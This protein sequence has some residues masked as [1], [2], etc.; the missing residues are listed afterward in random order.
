MS[1]PARPREGRE[2]IVLAPAGPGAFD[3]I[4][5]F[6]WALTRALGASQPSTLVVRGEPTLPAATFEAPGAPAIARMTSWSALS[7]APWPAR[8]RDAAG[9]FVQYYPQAY[10]APDLPPLMHWLAAHKQAGGAVVV[11]L[12]EYWPHASWSPPRELLRWRSRRALRDLVDVSTAMVVSQ[13]FSAREVID[14][15]LVPA[16]HLHVIPIGSAVPKTGPRTPAATRPVLAMFG[17]PAMV[18]SR[19]VAALLQWIEQA[20][21][22]P[23]LWWFSRSEDELRQW[24]QREIGRTSPAVTFFGG[25]SAEQLSARLREATLGLALYADGAS[26]RRS[27]LAALL[28]HGLPIAGIDGRYTDD[29]LR[30]SGALWLVTIADPGALVTAVATLL[31]DSGRQAEMSAAAERFFASTLSWPRLAD[32]YWNLAAR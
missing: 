20:P 3:G 18:D 23:R 12:H 21:V 6:S 22:S 16:G 9:V 17:Q 7:S 8:G 31:Q 15:T 5:D 27:S 19:T 28:E 10:V 29:R 25:L 26:T 14:S 30:A 2:A 24:W 1:A 11:T 13:P 32:A 4:G